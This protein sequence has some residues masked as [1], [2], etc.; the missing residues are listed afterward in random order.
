MK[1][2]FFT[3]LFLISCLFLQAQK[4]VGSWTDRLSYNY[5][6]QIAIGNTEIFASTESAIII[7]DTKYNEVKKLS[8]V[9]GLSESGIS[10]I[11]YSK[12]HN[13]LIIGYTSTN[14]DLVNGNVIYNLPDLKLKYMP[15]E[16]VINKIH[17]KGQYAYFACSFGIVVIDIVKKEIYDTWKPGSS[18]GT[19][20]VNDL[21]FK[22]DF[23]YATTD[24]GVYFARFSTQGLSYFGNWTRIDNLPEPNAR[25]TNIISANNKIFINR[26]EEILTGDKVYV[27]D[28]TSSLFSFQEGVYYKSF[29]TSITGFTLTTSDKIKVYNSNSLLT[30]EITSYNWGL[31]DA[32]Q[33]VIE[34]NNIWITD[35]NHGLIQGVNLVTFQS[36][37]P[38]GPFTNNVTN[39]SQGEGRIFLAGGGVDN[40]WNNLWR[41]GQIFSFENNRWNSEVTN[42]VKDIMRIL[43]EP[44]NSSHYFVSTWGGGLLEY[45]NNSLINH[46]D[47]NSPSPLQSIIPGQPYTRI[48]GM[49][50]DEKKNLWIT[51]SGVTGSIK[52]LKPDGTWIMNPITIDAPTIGDII[53]ARSGYKWILLPRGFGLF[54]LDDN[55]TPG[56]FSDDRYKKIIVKDTE[57]NVFSNLYSITEDLDGDIWVGTDQGPV[58]YYNPDNVFEE[59]P[60]VLRSKISRND[61][62]G[63]A[64]YMLGTEII[65]SI[66]VDGD[67]RKW[68]GTA[69]SGVYLLSSDGTKQILNYNE[70]NSPLLSNSVVCVAVEEKSGEIWFGTDKGTIS[71]RGEATTGRDNFNNIYSFP[72]PVRESFSG[73][74]TITGL[75]R[76]TIVKITDVSGNLVYETTSTGGQASWDLTTY[77]GRHVTTGVYIVFCSNEDGSESA[78]TK[79]LIIK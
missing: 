10:T 58:I 44:G 7:Y 59:D 32:L 72:N 30:K 2:I 1:T 19:S 74:V 21:A 52:V 64:D 12:D 57:G 13:T 56:T 11:D 18:N 23:I 77:N 51:Q 63:L 17:S 46:F 22:D 76:N 70:E 8:R 39:I 36:L 53:I 37:V 69:S 68:V 78:T 47:Q 28:N 20:E 25:Y 38:N 61:G 5:A 41:P 34:G 49:A 31:P 54:I 75:M 62:T 15:G 43:P 26:S 33:A 65:T 55:N 42:N 50:F 73:N 67:N 60:R 27:I 35:K 40:A 4:P 66:A 3:T 9:D 48:C 14:I 16:K 71:L 6:R 24:N 29:D 45:S 79:M